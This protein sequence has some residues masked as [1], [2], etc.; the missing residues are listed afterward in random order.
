[1]VDVNSQACNFAYNGRPCPY[2]YNEIYRTEKN[3]QALQRGCCHPSASNEDS[4][5]TISTAF[6]AT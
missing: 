4:A 2:G 6:F 3:G 5:S 1:M